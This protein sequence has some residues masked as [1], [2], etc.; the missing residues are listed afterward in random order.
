MPG[1]SEVGR[2]LLGDVVGCDV[3]IH[4]YPAVTEQGGDSREV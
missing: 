2:L 3:L 1:R 4:R